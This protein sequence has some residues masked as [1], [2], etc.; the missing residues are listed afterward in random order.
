MTKYEL[1]KL[2]KKVLEVK[3]KRKRI[4][5]LLETK[6]VEEFLKLIQKEGKKLDDNDDIGILF[7]ILKSFEIKETNK[8]YV[9][10]CEYYSYCDICYE[11]TS[12]SLEETNINS[13]YGKY[14]NYMDIENKDMYRGYL[15]EKPN[16]YYDEISSNEFEKENIVLNPYG[17]SRKLNGYQE[18][19]KDFFT[20]AI[21]K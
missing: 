16:L 15:K 18:V 17:T 7:E 14:R 4:N 19:R 20:Y 3:D 8:I 9:C 5:S 21:S 10:I 12:Y 1:I 2:K 11:D 13:G 6:E